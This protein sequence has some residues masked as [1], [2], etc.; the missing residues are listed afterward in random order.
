MPNTD[1]AESLE[2]QESDTAQSRCLDE[3]LVEAVAQRSLHKP[4]QDNSK[5]ELSVIK[6][7]IKTVILPALLMTGLGVL[8][9][10]YPHFFDDFDLNHVRGNDFSVISIFL[11]FLFVKL[12]WN[13]VGGSVAIILSLWAIIKC[14]LP[15]KPKPNNLALIELQPC[16]ETP[17][18]TLTQEAVH[19]GLQTGMTVGKNFLQRRKDRRIHEKG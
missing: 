14:F 2:Q 4:L 8:A 5:P 1:S 3:P 7:K 10:V 19:L 13:Q 15:N 18:K 9:I 16:N 6:Y 12:S 11:L 17:Q